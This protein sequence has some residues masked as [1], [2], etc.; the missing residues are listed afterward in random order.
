VTG[1]NTLKQQLK[2]VRAAN[3]HEIAEAVT[4]MYT[5]CVPAVVHGL[6]GNRFP[7]MLVWG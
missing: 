7:R 6:R 1:T 3:R 2:V 5:L 4:T